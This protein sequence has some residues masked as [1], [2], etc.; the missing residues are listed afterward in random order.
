MAGE[1]DAAGEGESTLSR[2]KAENSCLQTCMTCLHT[3]CG[4]PQAVSHE[5]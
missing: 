4:G 1:E 2:L 3:N 5:Q